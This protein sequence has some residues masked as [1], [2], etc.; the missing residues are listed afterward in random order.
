MNKF[1]FDEKLT[2]LRALYFEKH[3]IDPNE[4]EV[5]TPLSLEEKEQKTLNSLQ[6]CVADIAHLSADIDSLKSQDAP[7]ESIAALET[8]LRELE[9]RKLILEQKLEFI[10]SGETDDQKKEKLKRQILELEVKRSKLKM[11]QKDCS[12]IDLK[13]KQRLDIYK[14]L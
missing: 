3:P 12:K 9:D 10:L 11:A 13:I 7:E 14:K 6:D 4:S 2:E 1:D 8:R 5:F